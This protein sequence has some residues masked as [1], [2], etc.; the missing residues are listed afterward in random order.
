[1]NETGAGEGHHLGL[2]LAPP[3]QR[4]G[5][6]AGTAQRVYLL[7]GLDHAAIDQT[8]HD[9]R[10]L[11]RD[12]RKHGLVEERES[13]LDLPLPNESPALQVTGA[14]DQVGISKAITNLGG[15]AAVGVRGVAIA[16]GEALLSDG[17]QQ[18]AVLY[19]VAAFD[20]A[21]APARATRS[22]EP[23]SPRSKR[24]RP[25]QKAQRAARA[26]V[27]SLHMRMVS[28][29]EESLKVEVSAGQVRRC[30]Q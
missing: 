14:G 12:D 10:Q 25:N 23:V 2:L 21:G 29:I 17:Q 1:M 20:A 28:T 27:A 24:L 13:S 3:G 30:R 15:A 11:S 9:G 22:P 6:L 26:S 18:V 19:A 16:F 7:A 8:R 5:P 4:G